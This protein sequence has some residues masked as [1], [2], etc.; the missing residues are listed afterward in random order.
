MSSYKDV[1]LKYDKNFYY[2]LLGFKD[3]LLENYINKD[4]TRTKFYS[5]IEVFKK[6]KYELS[7]LNTL[8]VNEDL[9]KEKSCKSSENK[10]RDDIVKERKFS[11][12]VERK[13]KLNS[14]IKLNNITNDCLNKNTEELVTFPKN[15]KAHSTKNVFNTQAK[16]NSY[17]TDSTALPLLNTSSREVSN[18]IKEKID[19][20]KDHDFNNAQTQKDIKENEENKYTNPYLNSNLY[21]LEKTDITTEKQKLQIFNVIKAFSVYDIEISYTQ[22]INFIAG[23]L[24]LHTNSERVSFWIL[25][26][27]M[28]NKNWRG[29]FIKNTPRLLQVIDLFII[30]LKQKLPVLYKH[31][32]DIE[33]LEFILGIF[34]H[35]FI[36]LFSYNVYIEFSARIMDLFFLIEDKVIIDTLLHLLYL[37][38]EELLKMN[39]EEI[40]IY[41]KNSFIN[42]CIE[43]Y[44]IN[45]CIPY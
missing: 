5:M 16:I 10:A 23:I 7:D 17:N 19:Y 40:A 27:I 26:D 38:Q 9:D 36:T 30:K 15:I 32:S 2:S 4:I 12:R 21:F 24:L 20:G 6:V 33:F 39:M 34:S 35:F 14:N 13:N 31:F 28:E 41:I 11:Y 44:G 45:Y 1:Y 22:G 42:D 37:K 25:V 29:L 18:D 8:K 43:E 3:D